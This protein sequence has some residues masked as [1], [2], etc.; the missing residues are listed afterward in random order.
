MSKTAAV[1]RS[2]RIPQFEDLEFQPHQI[3]GAVQ[4]VLMFENGYGVSVV[5]GHPGLYGNGVDTFEVAVI[6]GHDGKGWEI[7]Y[8]TD[9]TND[10]MAWRSKDELVEAMLRVSSLPAFRECTHR[11]GD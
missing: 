5:G 1:L 9:I 4:A 3:P 11:H 7:C 6:H 8:S 10:V 2:G